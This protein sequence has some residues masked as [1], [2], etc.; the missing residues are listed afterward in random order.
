MI[1]T[2]DNETI[3]TSGILTQMSQLE[4][5][6]IVFKSGSNRRQSVV[7]KFETGAANETNKY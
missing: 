7:S 4:H 3:S 6:Q 2:K 5:E 1:A